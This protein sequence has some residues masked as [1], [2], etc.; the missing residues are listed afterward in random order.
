MPDCI[1]KHLFNTLKIYHFFFQG[2]DDLGDL[3]QP[4]G[5]DG[6]RTGQMRKNRAKDRE[7]LVENDLTGR[8]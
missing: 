8:T 2:K 1:S 6:R 4:I 3:G 7:F 5:E